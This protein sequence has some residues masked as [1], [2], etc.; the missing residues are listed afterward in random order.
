MFHAYNE[1]LDERQA[2]YIMRRSPSRILASMLGF[3]LVISILAAC[4][5][6]ATQTNTGNGGN[7][8][9]QQTI[10]IKIG[11]ELPTTA[12][13]ASTGKPAQDGVQLAV[14]EA[15]ADPNFLP[16]YKFVLVPKDDVGINGTH[17]P[18]TGQKNVTDLIGDAQVA[19]I[20]G[21]INSSVALAEIPTTNKAPIALISPSN[22]NDCLTKETPAFECGGANSKMAALRPT[23]KVTYFRTATIDQY[24]GAALAVYGYKNKNYRSVYVLDD[25]EAYGVGLAQN[26]TTYWKKL[27]GTVVGS[28]SIKQTNS[29]ENILTEIAAKRP[30]FIFFGGNDSTGGITIRQQMKTVAGLANTPFF[31]GDGAKTSALA[32]AV[33][34]LGG[35]QVFA[36][37]P[38]VDPSQSPAS[39]TFFDAYT[40]QFGSDAIGAYSA[41]GYDCAKILLQAIQTVVKN[42]K[43]TAPKDSGDDTGAA[44]FRQAVIDAVQSIQYDGVTGHH[45]FDKNGDTSNHFISLYTIGDLNTGDGWKYLE[46]I[47]TS[48]LQ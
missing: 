4:G 22:T 36:S 8:G 5:S 3:T 32:K 18:T 48:S 24:Q 44:T 42:K 39:K 11:S 7:G 45:S 35:G 46:Q 17:D 26:F 43:A 19:G 16:G 15:N 37:I 1:A 34:P 30:D 9:T 29:Y 20:V 33:K 40:K 28:A 25:T 21:P 38:G 13:D 2:D 12:G 47:D 14:Q 10:T 23:G 27:G 6:G 41:G 31:A